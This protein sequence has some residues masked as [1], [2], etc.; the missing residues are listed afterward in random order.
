MDGNLSK[1]LQFS[2]SIGWLEVSI[3]GQF[4]Y[5][6]VSPVGNIRVLCFGTISNIWG[7]QEKCNQYPII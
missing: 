3:E 5:F 7:Q 1:G 2:T 6:S 4:A